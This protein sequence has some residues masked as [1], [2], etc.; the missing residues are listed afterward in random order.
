M[1]KILPTVKILK[2]LGVTIDSDLMFRSHIQEICIHT[3][4][5]I[6]VLSRLKNMIST[7]TKFHFYKFAILPNLT[8]CHV[9]W[10]F[11]TKSD[12]RKLERIQERALRIVFKEKSATYEEL[13]EK[14][15][16]TTLYN[17]RLQDLAIMMYKVK[18]KLLPSYVVDIFEENET[19]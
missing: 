1:D 13:L 3:S 14:A 19:R 12:R 6:G 17:R 15:K 10:N 16:L 8:Y 18:Y 4:K 5:K 9:L 11:C 2:L 7:E